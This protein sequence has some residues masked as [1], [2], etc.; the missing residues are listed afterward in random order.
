MMCAP[1]EL[2]LAEQFRREV[3]AALISA[4]DPEHSPRQSRID[5]AR[6]YHL[7]YA[8]VTSIEREG[9]EEEWE[10]L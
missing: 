4:Y 3:F 2:C 9:F 8:L 1:T 6:E 10:P 5:V 7:S